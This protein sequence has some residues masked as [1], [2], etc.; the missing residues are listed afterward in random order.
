MKFLDEDNILHTALAAVF[1]T[2]CIG[3]TV[4]ITAKETAASKNT[5][6]AKRLVDKGICEYR[7]DPKTGRISL[8][9]I[10]GTNPG[11]TWSKE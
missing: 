3:L 4:I 11:E 2:F 1:F 9:L 7:I 5:A 10:A 8:I 6:V